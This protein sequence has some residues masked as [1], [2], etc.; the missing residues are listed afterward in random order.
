[1]NGNQVSSTLAKVV[2]L[3]GDLLKK[4]RSYKARKG[5]NYANDDEGSL[6]RLSWQ[7]FS[8]WGSG[9]GVGAVVVGHDV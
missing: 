9:V 1:L 5:A 7:W 3:L 6:L 4:K 2:V 8:T